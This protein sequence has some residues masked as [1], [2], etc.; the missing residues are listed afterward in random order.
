MTTTTAA[1]P[2]CP[3]CGAHLRRGRPEGQLCDPCEG[4]GQR[5]ELPPGF[6]ETPVLTAALGAGDFGPVFGAVRAELGWTQEELGEFVGLDRARVSDIERGVRLLRDVRNAGRVSTRLEIPAG[7]LGFHG[8]ITVGNG[9][10]ATGR[11][12]SWM[13]RR[14]F[15]QRVAGMTLGL[16]G[17]A[18]ALD[19]DRLRALLPQPDET[20]TRRI[21][22][23]D[24]DLIEQATDVFRRQD[25]AHGSVLS[26]EAAVAQLGTVLPLLNAQMSDAVRPRLHVA[27]ASLATMAGWMSFEV[28]NHDAARRLWMI[29]LDVARDADD[30]IGTDLT[31]FVL[32]DLVIQALHLGRGDE[33][34]QLIKLA[35]AAAGG[36]KYPISP[37]TA[38][39]LAAIHA[40]ADAAAGDASGCDRHLDEAGA[41]LDR[42]RGDESPPWV[43]FVSAGGADALRGAAA[44]ELARATGDTRAATRAVT[45]LQ[46]G[47]DGFGPTYAR[48]RA[49]YLPDLSGAFALAGDPDRAVSIGHDAI[50]AIA[51]VA[52]PRAHDQLRVLGAV[53]EPVRSSA[54]VTELRT[55]L[56]SVVA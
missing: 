17:G 46:A 3:K 51:A 42:I 40:R 54:G 44:Y 8:G 55:R 15:V 29:A 22:C 49:R 11:K 14:D 50:D 48:P 10:G 33:A 2:A 37:A 23:A 13:I 26:R 47:I 4:R 6:Y 1:R 32:Y 35:H 27:T 56:T 39:C 25:F 21:G 28:R 9:E 52:S 16:V 43:T 12:V 7:K 53:L 45:L 41:H 38:S 30:Q 34:A 36:G 20:P 24:V 19:L 5:L 18:N 31:V